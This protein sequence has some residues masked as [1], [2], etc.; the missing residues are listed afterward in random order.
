MKTKNELVRMIRRDFVKLSASV[1]GGLVTPGL[2]VQSADADDVPTDTGR[3]LDA[4]YLEKGLNALARAHHMSSMAG[5]LGASLIAGYYIGEQRPNLDPQVYE[6]IKGDLQRV[7]GGDSVFGKEM[8]RG[9]KLSD[10]DL[11]EPFPKQRADETLID[12]IAEGLEKSIDKPRQSG[13]NVIFASLAIRALKEHPEYATPA[14]VD[15]IVKLMN[16]FT[17]QTPGSG[18]YGKKKG[19]IHGHKISLPHDDT[20]PVYG[21]IEGMVIAVLDEAIHLNPKIHRSGYGG[22]VHV[23]NHAAAITDLAACGYVELASR[24]IRSHRH[25]LRLW[26]NLPDLA[27]EMGPLPVSKFT[28]HSAAYW[29]SGNVPYD[30]ALLTHR[31][32]TMFGFDELATAINEEAKEKAAYDKLRYMM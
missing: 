15:G 24:A 32:K 14:V 9:S 4:G 29:T 28:P 6:G 2:L 11:F 18:Y 27:D 17:N 20:T 31:V 19:R 16:L 10:A 25:H 26:R 21:D 3:S 13:H 23:I 12:G 8:S 7:I 5:H 30:R 1:A 22:L